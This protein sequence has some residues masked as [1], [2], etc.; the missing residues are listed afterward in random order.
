MRNKTCIL[1]Y[2][3]KEMVIWTQSRPQFVEY[4][5]LLSRP[6]RETGSLWVG[7]LEKGTFSELILRVVK[8]RLAFTTTHS[9]GRFPHIHSPDDHRLKP[10]LSHAHSPSLTLWSNTH[11]ELL[12]VLC[13]LL[14]WAKVVGLCRMKY[15]SSAFY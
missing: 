5:W 6:F 10:T 11:I 2:I 14:L 1:N 12:H 8:W 15:L 13:N 3:L 9:L 7:T 4:F